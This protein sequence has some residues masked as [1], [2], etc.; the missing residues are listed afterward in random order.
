MGA[1]LERLRGRKVQAVGDFKSLAVVMAKG[2]D[3]PDIDAVDRLLVASGKTGDDLDVVVTDLSLRYAAAASLAEAERL[4][5]RADALHAEDARHLERLNAEKARA[6]QIVTDAQ[7]VFNAAYGKGTALDHERRRLVEEARATLGRT[8]DPSI[9][10]DIRAAKA[11]RERLVREWQDAQQA[12]GAPDDENRDHKRRAYAANLK[13]QADAI[14][15]RV[16]EL[17]ARKLDPVGG[18]AW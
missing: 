2:G 10:A 5:V 8:A 15:A 9:E 6:E 16:R 14:E 3:V 18:M 12:L 17:D 13:A 4:K 1:L 7:A 11:E